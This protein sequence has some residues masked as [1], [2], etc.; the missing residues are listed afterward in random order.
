MSAKALL[1]FIDP[2]DGPVI[3]I[4]SVPYPTFW[5]RGFWHSTAQLHPE[6]TGRESSKIL[7][8]CGGGWSR[9]KEESQCKAV[10][11]AIE[12]WCFQWHSKFSPKDAG[13]DID[14]TTNGF[15]AL[16]SV[17]GKERVIGNAYCEA[18]ERWALNRIWDHGDIPV[19]EITFG[20]GRLSKLFDTLKGSGRCFKSILRQRNG[21]ASFS[22]ENIFCLA[23]FKTKDGGVVPGS[24]CGIN[25]DA[26]AER[27]ILE[28]Y[29]HA[30]A[31]DRMKKNKMFV[32]DN[33]LEKRLYFFGSNPKARCMVEERLKCSEPVIY[34]NLPRICFSRDLVGPWG[35]EVLVHRLLLEDSR[36][37]SEGGVERFLI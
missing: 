12:R 28:A 20:A 22:G 15:A 19:S 8:P 16:P 13:L 21:D 4:S 31:Y 27:A 24:A 7:Q 1:K 3:S 34:N 32:F 37:F 10:T 30:R 14:P 36:P 33:I 25:P 6:W 5:R 29:I 17:F 9:D 2:A 26:T 23:L 11:E 18:L 35:P